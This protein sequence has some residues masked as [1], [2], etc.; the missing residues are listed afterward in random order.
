M[1]QVRLR[2][3]KAILFDIGGTVTYTTFMD[4]NLAYYA[5]KHVRVF[6]SNNWSNSQVVRDVDMTRAHASKNKGWP[7]VP[8]EPPEAVWDSIQSAMNFSLDNDQDCLG[9][10]QLR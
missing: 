5:R 9:L 8:K 7:Q 4:K 10:A 3:P 1:P 2:K 6:L